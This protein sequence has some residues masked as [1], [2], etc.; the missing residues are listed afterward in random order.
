MAIVDWV[1]KDNAPE[2]IIGTKFINDTQSLGVQFQRAHCKY[3]K[4][5]QYK[6]EG[7]PNVIGSWECID[8]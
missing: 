8:A 3:P 2:T 5:N 7:D 1:E 4:R 6:G